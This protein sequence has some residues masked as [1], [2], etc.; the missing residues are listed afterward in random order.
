MNKTIKSMLLL[1]LAAVGLGTLNSCSD[2]DDSTMSRLFRPVLSNS[3]IIT[4]LDAEKVPYLEL[5]WDSYADADKYVAVLVPSNGGDSIVITTDTST[6]RFNNLAYD[7][8]YLIKLKAIST[9]RSL[10]SKFYQTSVTTAD[11]PTMLNNFTSSTIIDTQAKATWDADGGKT[12]Y[13]LLKLFK[14]STGEHI[15]DIVVTDADL[16]AGQIFISN[17]EPK[18]TYRLEA[19][20]NGKYL[21]KKRFTTTAPENYDGYV[22]DMRGMDDKESERFISTETLDSIVSHNPGTDVT[23]VLK[24]G[25]S[26]K[27]SGGTTIPAMANKIKFVT[28]LS[29]SGNATIISTGG[30]TIGKD[31]ADVKEIVFE[32]INF[33]SDKARDMESLYDNTDKG[34]G[35]RQVFNINGVKSTVETLTFKNC[36]ITGYRAVVRGQ[37]AN[38][39]IH[40]IKMEDCVVNAIGDQ[41]VFTNADKGGDWRNVSLK[42]CTFTNIVMLCDFRKTVNPLEMNVENCTFCY[43]PMETNSNANTPLFRFGANPVT[44][45]VKNTLFGPAM[46]SEES[47]GGAIL[48]YRAG[49]IGSVLM[50]ATATTAIVLNSYKTNFIYTD[51]GTEEAPKTYP[52]EGVETLNMSETQLWSNPGEGN[53]KIIATLD[54]SN[55]GDSRWN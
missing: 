52:I 26:Y 43:A 7:A 27:I 6:C 31:G 51:F 36:S 37:T 29:L 9:K 45:N 5:K 50:N 4:G 1:A 25:M 38:D 47:A 22:F 2:D 30:M 28:G 41:G 40:N 11:Y 14:E 33:I 39:H 53:F 55:V 54:A 24:G 48:P 20:Y 19:Y 18:T 16:A 32:K 3:N 46:A 44:L 8:E 21:G 15:Q 34:W 35:G 23:I 10:E 17:L 49:V 13:D 12:R 42:N